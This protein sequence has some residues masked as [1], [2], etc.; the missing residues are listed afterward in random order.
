MSKVKIYT[1]DNCPYCDRAKALL[2]GRGIPFEEIKLA[3]DDEEAWEALIKRSGMQTVPQIFVG[4]ELI[5]GYT[6]LAALD[7][8]TELKH[9]QPKPCN[10]L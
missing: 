9:L 10:P 5:G 7:Q 6:D 8:T 1:M 4:D 3:D 2:N